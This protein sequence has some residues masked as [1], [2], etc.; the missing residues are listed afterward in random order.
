M[1]GELALAR[2]EIN[3]ARDE[4]RELGQ[5]TFLGALEMGATEV[6][7]TAG[8]AEAALEAGRVGIGHLEAAGEQGWL[9]TLFGYV[10]EALYR[11]GRDEEAWQLTTRAEEAGA[12]DDVM[13]LML[14]RQVRSKLL[15]RSGEL[16]EAERL[17][18]EAVA[19]SPG[20]EDPVHH[21]DALVDLAHV[22]AAAG[23]R[24]EALE[25]LSEAHTFFAGKG[26]TVGVARVEEMRS[27]LGATLG[28]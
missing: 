6:E 25:V 4:A 12:E 27:D 16:E 23:K 2:E 8:S 24:D 28:S 18:R 5:L 21:A 1:R 14:V 10:A 9:S 13:T 19:M 11:L 17:A 15:A 26:H 22:L 3:R 7:L 20:P